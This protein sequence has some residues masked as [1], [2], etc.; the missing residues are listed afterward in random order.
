M[1]LWCL[2]DPHCPIRMWSREQ[3]IAVHDALDELLF[4][5]RRAHPD[6]LRDHDRWDDIVED[7]APVRGDIDVEV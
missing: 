4:C 7:S 6:V 3:V 5:I 2:E 1:S